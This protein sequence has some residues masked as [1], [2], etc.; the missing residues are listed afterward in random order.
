M[1]SGRLGNSSPADV[2]LIAR[3]MLLE[4]MHRQ[5]GIT[6]HGT[7]ED[8][9]KLTLYLTGPNAGGIWAEC[10]LSTEDL[11]RDA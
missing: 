4:Q 6:L 11:A 3:G 7:V 5:V 8:A 9:A 1:T 10:I 2:N